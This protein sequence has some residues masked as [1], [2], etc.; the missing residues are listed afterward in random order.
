MTAAAPASMAAR[1]PSRGIVISL[2]AQINGFF[3]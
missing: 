2:D 3:R 1:I